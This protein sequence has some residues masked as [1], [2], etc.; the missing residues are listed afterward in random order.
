[1]AVHTIQTEHWD[2][3]SNTSDYGNPVGAEEEKK[4]V[5]ELLLCGETV[6]READGVRIGHDSERD[7]FYLIK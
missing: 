2:I 4:H 3:L 5:K 7:L 1:M 6:V